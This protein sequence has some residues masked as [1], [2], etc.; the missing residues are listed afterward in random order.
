MSEENLEAY[1]IAKRYAAMINGRLFYEIQTS[2]GLQA[3]GEF[4]TNRSDEPQM[5]GM[6]K[7]TG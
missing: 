5:L 2:V 6:Q 7:H 3:Q 4:W 1:Q